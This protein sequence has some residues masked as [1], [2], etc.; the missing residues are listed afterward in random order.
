MDNNRSH[1]ITDRSQTSQRVV[2]VPGRTA[3]PQR[4]PLA[5]D[6]ALWDALDVAA[7]LKASRS[8]VYHQA[9]AGLLPCI[10]IGG[11]LRFDPCAIR[12]FVGQQ[13]ATP[14]VVA[15]RR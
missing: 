9:E 8:W 13:Q 1:N 4:L 14:A 5:P 15:G 7:Y 6:E 11:L 12:A 3:T 10:R 2:S